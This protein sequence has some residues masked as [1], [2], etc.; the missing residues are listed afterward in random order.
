[1][2]PIETG[3]KET[4]DFVLGHLPR[5]EVR[6]LE[7]G[8][9]RGHLTAMLRAEGVDIRG[10]D[11]SEEAVEETRSRGL[12][13]VCADFLQFE[14]ELYDVVFFSRSLHHIHPTAKALEK[15]DALLKPDGLLIVEDFGV[16]LADARSVAWLYGTESLLQKA[17]LL[18]EEADEYRA[19]DDHLARWKT[20]HSRHHQLADSATMRERLRERFAAKP[21][22]RAP[23]LYRYLLNSLEPTERGLLVSRHLLD[24]ERSLSA[25]SALPAIGIRW[26]AVKS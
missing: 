17:G 25:A 26:V 8:C 9:G 2:L 4:L 13:A 5:R 15:A 18:I 23:Y 24:W 3:A 12:D 16:E 19:A 10:I 1:M 14:D 22:E 11:I 7:V 6:L 20:Y 21:E